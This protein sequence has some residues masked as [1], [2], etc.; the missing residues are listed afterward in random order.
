MSFFDVTKPEK[1]TNFRKTEH[2]DLTPGQTTIRILDTPE[3][4][5]KFSTH[6][7]KGVYIKCLGE[8]CP[9]CK[10]NLKIFSENPDSY[11]EIAGWSPKQARY[12]V[13][14]YDKTTV[15]VCPNCKAEV[16]KT[17]ASFLPVCPKCNQPIIEV[18]EAPLNKIKVLAKGV[19]VA[20][21]LNGI[22]ESILDTEGNKV[23]INNFDIVLY[24][25]GTGKNQTISPIP[26]VDKTELVE[27]SKED[28]FDLTKIAVE[29]TVDEITDL[30]RGISLKDIFAARRSASVSPDFAEG[31][32]E[33]ISESVKRD[34]DALLK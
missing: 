16:K 30:Q 31:K 18:H 27:Y 13:N 32:P 10:S 20:E 23:G 14:V 33:D 25:T 7:V 6:Y 11:R 26:L 17:G 9:I 1:S 19:T 12:A 15:K 29:L 28:K 34:I 21:L 5:Y 24:V 4:A 2:L 3:E 8:D 22:N